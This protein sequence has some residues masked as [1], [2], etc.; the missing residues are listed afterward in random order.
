MN[1]QARQSGPR[2]SLKTSVIAAIVALL[3]VISVQFDSNLASAA[4]S[5]RV[6]TS[7][8]VKYASGVLKQVTKVYSSGFGQAE[9][10]KVEQ[11]ING[12]KPDSPRC[13]SLPCSTRA[14]R[15]SWKSGP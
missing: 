11:D 7:F 2:S 15:S 4:D 10:S 12:L 9:A 3:A 8:D 6:T 5:V 1:I 13:G 14:R